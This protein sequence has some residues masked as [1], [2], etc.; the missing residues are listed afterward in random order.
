MISSTEQE[1]VRWIGKHLPCPKCGS[2]D[3]ASYNEYGIW[4]C[5]GCLADWYDERYDT[6]KQ[7]ECV[8]M[9][10]E[11]KREQAEQVGLEVAT[12]ETIATILPEGVFTAIK[13]RGISED[14]CRKYDVT[15]DLDFDGKVVTHHYPYCDSNGVK[16]A[17][18]TRTVEGKRFSWSGAT[19]QVK[20]FFGQNIFQPKSTGN[21]FLFITEG[22]SDCMAIYQMTGYPA[23]SVPNGAT[24]LAKTIKD[25]YDYVNSFDKIYICMDNDK[26]GRESLEVASALFPPRKT[27]ISFADKSKGCKDA[28]DY[29]MKGLELDFKKDM[30]WNAKQ[31]IP[32][33]IYDDLDTIWKEVQGE[34]NKGGGHP[35]PWVGLNKLLYGMSAGEL[36]TVIAGTGCVDGET[37]FFTGTGWKRI[38]EYQ[39]G[40]K[41][42]QFDQETGIASLIEPEEYIQKPCN[43]FYHFKTK[44]G[45]DMMLS[46]EH[47]VLYQTDTG[48]F[49][50]KSV[51][52]VVQL[53]DTTVKGFKG[54]IPCA[55][56]YQEGSGFNLS[57]DEIRFMLAVIADGSF[58]SK[59]G[60]R[61]NLKKE[62]KKIELKN[63]LDALGISYTWK[64]LPTGF[65]VVHTK[66]PRSEKIFT[67][68]WY[69]CS[70][71]QLQLI[72][73]N[74]LKWDG[75]IKRGR[76]MFFSSSKESA[77]FIQFAFTSCG[78]RARIYTQDRRGRVK[79][80]LA[81]NKEYETKSIDYVVHI[82]DKGSTT[83]INRNKKPY[84]IVEGSFTKYCFT[85][86][87]HNLVLRRNGCIFVTGNSGKST[88]LRELQYHLLKT[89]DERM[90]LL[91]LEET[92]GRTAL[93]VMSLEANIPLHKPDAFVSEQDLKS[94]YDR[95]I[96]LGK[97]SFYGGFKCFDIDTIKARIEYMIRG[98]DCKYIFL[99]HISILVSNQE[100]SD[101][102]KTLDAVA[103]CLAEIAVSY[104]VCIIMVSHLRRT[105]AK[106]HEEGG[107]TSL[108]DIRGSQGIGQLSFTVLGLE[109]NQQAKDP[110]D[111]NTILIRVLK[112]RKFGET[113]PACK[114]VFDSDTGRLKEVPLD[115]EDY[116]EGDGEGEGEGSVLE[117]LDSQVAFID[118]Q[119]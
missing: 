49:R 82:S 58:Y 34:R 45:L 59:T 115:G 86:P 72:C 98:C 71:E 100:V 111:R 94:Y 77:D 17:V 74:V 99:D 103:H 116:L 109:R 117:T 43:K 21:N 75:S 70:K 81:T 57:D 14:T 4:H 19:K 6:R 118:K 88:V 85:V 76:K 39:E 16:V 64:E 60:V 110:K 42:L 56:K 69:S 102:R 46:E 51:L 67:Q 48:S 66:A 50:K 25:N 37:E 55:F 23:V 84:S 24:S 96:G 36:V 93:G 78:Y 27:Y 33:G 54:K 31:F 65:A 22:C 89:T 10:V 1:P 106:P 5:F 11:E 12:I 38:D 107:Q 41:V 26:V 8:G 101:E 44:Y 63:I 7:G 68:D 53:C 119:T 97:I 108:Q 52:D 95:T 13:D 62:R 18:K 29:L 92:I 2:K 114:L 15:C 20:S 28:N 32:D 87:T 3:N 104:N 9:L 79:R 112:N 40:D 113:G 61:F 30:W 105:G 83:M 80:D 91:M 47:Q 35:Y 73:D 90:G